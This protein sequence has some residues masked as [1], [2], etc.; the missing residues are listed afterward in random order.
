[1][2]LDKNKVNEMVY[3]SKFAGTSEEFVQAGGGNTSVKID[4]R[5]MLIKASG[6]QLGEVNRENGYSVVDYKKIVE[7][8][9]NREEE[10]EKNDILQEVT[11]KGKKPSIETFLHSITDTYTIHT[12]PL[13][14][15]ILTTSSEGMKRLKEMF[16]EAVCVEYATPGIILAKKYFDAT[17]KAKENKIVFLK[18]HG[19]IVCA[20]SMNEA[21]EKTE[22]IVMEVNKSLG[23]DKEALEKNLELF[24]RLNKLDGQ[25]L[26]YDVTSESTKKAFEKASGVWEHKYTPDCVVYCG[27]KI[28][29]IKSEQNI[30]EML[31]T[32][33][34]EYGLPKA[35]M[36]GEHIFAVAENIGK[37]QEIGKV[38]D[39]TAKVYLN[40]MKNSVQTLSEEEVDFLL[41]WDSEKYRSQLKK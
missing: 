13:G 9:D 15:G 22:H 16:P 33:L 11:I 41:G 2:Y 23:L 18:N 5:Y 31:Q 4:D 7:W 30:E 34:L 38:L 17:K 40:S 12:H 27:K 35:V 24:K 32:Y 39:F 21:V 14:V 6:Y 8:L 10:L 20:S 26:V 3:I 37:A 1:M 36:W 25:I 29:E 19:L 28:F